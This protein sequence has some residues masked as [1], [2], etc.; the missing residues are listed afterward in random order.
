MEYVFDNE[1]EYETLMKPDEP[2]PYPDIPAE[3]PGIWTEE[4]EEDGGPRRSGK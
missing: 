4:L 1:D 3:A 2:S